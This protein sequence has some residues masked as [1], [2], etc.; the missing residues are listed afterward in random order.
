MNVKDSTVTQVQATKA[1]DE[2]A[3]GM[4]LRVFTRSAL[5]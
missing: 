3:R 2:A 5:H 1:P 4:E